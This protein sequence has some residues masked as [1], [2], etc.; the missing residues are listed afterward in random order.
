MDVII[1]S[2]ILV[3]LPDLVLEPVL[4]LIP[5]DVL[6]QLI[7]FKVHGPLGPH[8]LQPVLQVEQQQQQ[9]KQP[10]QPQIVELHVVHLLKPSH[11]TLKPVLLLVLSHNGQLGDNAL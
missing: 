7:V 10:P 4:P 3:L 8:V 9:D 1:V 6:L 11:V 5:V 2:H